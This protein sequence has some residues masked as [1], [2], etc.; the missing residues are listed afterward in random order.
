MCYTRL[1]G[2]T[3]RKKLRKNHHQ[4]TIAKVCRAIFSQIRHLWTI[5]KKNIFKQ[6]YLAHMSPQYGELWHINGWDWLTSLWHHQQISTGFACWLITAPTSLNRG[7]PNF[8]R[9]LAVSCAGT[10]Y[11]FEGLL[12]SNGI[13]PIAKFT[14]RPSLVFYRA[15]WQRHCTAFEQWAAAILAGVVQGI[16]LRKFCFSSFSTESATYIPQAAITLVIG[17]HSS[18]LIYCLLQRN[19]VCKEMCG[20]VV[21]TFAGVNFLVESAPKSRNLHLQFRNIFRGDTPGP[22]PTAGG[23]DPPPPASMPFR[24]CT[25]QAPSVLG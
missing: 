3:G 1:A 19:A 17:P 16:E 4:R 6:Q 13:L 21:C 5:R 20:T 24:Q 10:L 25:R 8:A 18:N 7:Q 11:T 2:N 9:C 23:C 12:P 15:Y 14:L 22:H